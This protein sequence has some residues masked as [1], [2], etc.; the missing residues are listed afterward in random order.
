MTNKGFDA[1]AVLLRL[2]DS[3]SREAARLVLVDGLRQADAARAA[4]IS[5]QSVHDVIKSCR[6][7][8]NLIGIINDRG[9]K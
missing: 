7:A 8:L 9:E 4:G 5:Q 2:R 3:P 1:L 6:K